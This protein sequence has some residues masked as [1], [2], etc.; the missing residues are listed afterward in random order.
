GGVAA[1]AKALP[2]APGIVHSHPVGE[3]LGGAATTVVPLGGPLVSERIFA[4][5]HPPFGVTIEAPDLTAGVGHCADVAQGPLEGQAAA[6]GH[7][8]A[9][10]QATAVERERHGVRHGV[11]D[12][13]DDAVVVVA[14]LVDAT[15]GIGDR[16]DAVTG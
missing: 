4:A 8:E 14:Q 16:D 7:L 15:I 13:G 1:G 11:G 5:H 3:G 12:A 6:T 9:G 10:R 2:G